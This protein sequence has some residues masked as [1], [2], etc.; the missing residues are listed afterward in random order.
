MTWRLHNIALITVPLLVLGCGG[1]G[2]GNDDEDTTTDPEEESIEDATGEVADDVVEET[3]DD[4]VDDPTTETPEDAEEE[5]T[6]D[7]PEDSTGSG[8]VGDACGDADECGG[9]PA[10]DIRC[11][12]ELL[13]GSGITITFPEGYCS[14][15]CGSD[16]DCGE[17]ASCER[18]GSDINY[19][20]DECRRDSDCRED[21]GYECRARM[22]GSDTYC[23]PVRG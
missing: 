6:E 17:G 7:A 2:G 1:G 11:L 15:A 8:I 21:D 18:F 23:L 12:D 3:A 13:V 22:G 20:L 19:C 10:E 4:P 14:A 9:I 16:E 5:T